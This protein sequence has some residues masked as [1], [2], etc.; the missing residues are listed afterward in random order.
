MQRALMQYWIPGNRPLVREALRLARR[1]D[2]IGF[3]KKCLVHPEKTAGQ[4]KNKP[5]KRR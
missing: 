2:L 5:R 4:E 1:T 3:D